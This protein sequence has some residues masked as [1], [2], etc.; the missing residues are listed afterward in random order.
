MPLCEFEKFNRRTGLAL[1]LLAAG[2][3]VPVAA[4]AET[5]P[6][7]SQQRATAEKVAQA[8][9][10]LSELAANAPDSYTVKPH[11]TLWDISKLFLTTPWRWPELWGMNRDEIRNPNL[12]YPG[13][14]L[15]LVKTDGRAR[16]QLGRGIGAGDT[17]DT[18]K[19]SPRVRASTELDSAI[20]AIPTNLIEPFLTDAVVFDTD[21]LAK[22][23]RI[24]ATP[25]GRVLVTRGDIAYAR[26]DLSQATDYRIF[27]NATPLRDPATHEILGYEAPYLGTAELTRQAEVRKVDGKD[28]IVPATVLVK[29]V[30][31]EVG[32]GDRLSPVPQRYFASYV[33][34]APSQPIAGQI[35]ELYGD[36]VRGGQNQIV[37]LNRGSKDGLERG[38]VLALWRDGRRVTDHT[39]DKAQE[40]KLPDER[41]GILFVF[42]T[43]SRVSYALIISVTDAVSPGDRFTQP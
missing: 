6:V 12:I 5:Y 32:V 30:R 16:L 43:Y 23:P 3:L 25:E 37:S 2:F 28:E 18:V 29:T 21:E 8:G 10:P 31:Q 24:V 40:I 42:Q 22:A 20:A 34:H 9:V 39:G 1:S 4:H 36:A 11:D 19:L 15:L 7:T 27:R 17:S 33:P 35:I 13:Q 14:V 41:G 26:G 38:H